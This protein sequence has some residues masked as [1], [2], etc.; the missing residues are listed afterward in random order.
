M[1]GVHE[2][3]L[4]F[5]QVIDTLYDVSLTEHNIVPQRHEFVFHVASDCI[6]NYNIIT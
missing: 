6:S 1:S 4:V 2:V 5:E 3:P